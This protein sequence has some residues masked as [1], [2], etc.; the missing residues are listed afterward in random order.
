[1][2]TI[3]SEHK[4][5]YFTSKQLKYYFGDMSVGVFDIETL[6]LKPD[7]CAMILAGFMTVDE[8]G[9]CTLKQYFAETPEDEELILH[10]LK[11]DFKSVD[12]LF[13]YNG[14]HFDI[15]FVL[16]R[17]GKWDILDFDASL[18][19][20]DLYLVLNGHSEVKYLIENLKQKTVEAYMG[21]S[22]T[23]EDLITGAE[24]I[25][26][27]NA[28]VN[29]GNPEAKAKLENKILLHN[30]DDLLQLYQLLPIMKQVNIHKAFYHLG[31]P[32]YGASGWPSLNITSIKVTPMGLSISGKY[33]GDRFSYISYDSFDKHFFSEFKE[34]GTFNFLLHTDK[35]KGNV[36]I[37]LPLFVENIDD[38]RKY[39][40]CIKNFLLIS[41]NNS[42]SYMEVNVFIKQFI[43]DFMQNTI[44]PSA[45]L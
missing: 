11:D 37:N 39:P 28:Y 16:K 18:Y 40:N 20:L 6:G 12:Y 21:L 1:M 15:P 25:K 41:N 5:P 24:S 7:I 26:L 33:L 32:I 22:S 29:T 4:L 17:A 36:F 9:N 35:H 44:C 45:I 27:Y 42:I 34:D 19:N 31:F 10:H 38:F 3:I 13:T 8:D 23:R 14:K 43:S 30:H 2:K